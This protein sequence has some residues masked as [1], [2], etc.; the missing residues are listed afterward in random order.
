MRVIEFEYAVE[1][2]EKSV[3]VLIGDGPADIKILKKFVEK[4]TQAGEL[5]CSAELLLA[6]R[7]HPESV[8]KGNAVFRAIDVLASKHKLE[9][10]LV[11]YD[12]EHYEGMDEVVK[13][14][15]RGGCNVSGKKELGNN[16][17]H[18]FCKFGGRDVEIFFS[19]LGRKGNLECLEDCIAELLRRNGT[20]L[21]LADKDRHK[22]KKEIKKV[23]KRYGFENY[24]KLIL[25]SKVKDVKEAFKSLYLVLREI[26][27]SFSEHSQ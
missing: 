26:D 8:W 23:I 10:F 25:N 16:A 12:L 9:K 24:E 15:E 2:R 22:A 27:K 6:N 21:K 17:Y 4:L 3:F 13:A 11:F 20:P 14:L 19:V 18:I 5:S 1:P 7:K